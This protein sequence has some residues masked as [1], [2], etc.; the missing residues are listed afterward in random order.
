MDPMKISVIGA[1]SS[2]T[3]EIIEGLAKERSSLPVYEIVLMDIDEH[4]LEI[5][6]AFCRRFLDHIGCTEIRLTPAT[7]LKDA[8]AGSRFVVTQVRVGGNQQRILDEK[9]PL[10]YGLIGQETTGAGGMMKAF[11]TIPVMLELAKEVE[12]NNP[13]AWIINYTN[14]TGLITE[15]V[16]KYTKANIAGLCSGGLFPGW[17]TAKAL[18][19]PAETVT[20][21]YAGLNHLS[22]ASNI[23]VNGRA[24]SE[25][26]FDRVAEAAARG[27]VDYNIIRALRL[28]PSPYLQY[29]YHT[30]RRI[31]ATQK[32]GRTRGEEVLAIEQEIFREYA[33]PKTVT[34]P[35]AL[36]RRG[37]GGY[38][39][40]ALSVMKAVWT[41]QPARV[42]VNTPNRSAVRGLPEDA[43]VEIPCRISAA[44][45]ER[46]VSTHLP[47]SV[48]GLVAAVKNYEQLAVEAAV[49]GSR[50]LA[51]HALLA[52]PLVRDADTARP[53]LDELLEA[54]RSYLPQFSL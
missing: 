27:G 2:Y 36:K 34:K 19:V 45:I 22:F 17:Y 13:D 50:E 39:Q 11:R 23:R 47:A 29:Y 4:R 6:T 40:V 26:E 24:I 31:A 44:G 52:H 54:N 49:R 7:N 38:S 33:D 1:G 48:W 32:V 28:I 8:V 43:V 41:D 25:D 16:T 18:S 42:I 20:Y 37:G 3:P 46:L 12:Q 53:L 35:E 5:M 14:P 10:K 30:A 21:D 15:A 51:L 9:I